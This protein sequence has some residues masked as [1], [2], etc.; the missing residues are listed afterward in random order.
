MQTISCGQS[1]ATTTTVVTL[2]P[3][4][5]INNVSVNNM[6]ALKTEVLPFCCK[7]NGCSTYNGFYL[8]I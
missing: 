2:F 4:D 6:L 7:K 8:S 5:V 3:T 1:A